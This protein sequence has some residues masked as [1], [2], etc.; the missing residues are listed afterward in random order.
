MILWTH[1]KTPINPVVLVEKDGKLIKIINT[2]IKLP[3]KDVQKKLEKIDPDTYLKRSTLLKCAEAELIE[4]FE[5]NRKKFNIDYALG[6]TDF[7]IKVWNVI[8]SIPYG[9]TFSYGK[10]AKIMDKPKAARAVGSACRSN[11]V[12]VIIPCHRVIAA[13]GNLGDYSGGLVM[14]RALLDLEGVSYKLNK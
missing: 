9:Q 5:D 8:A 12:P 14:K 2:G 13:N 6:G 11:P 3:D 7:Q 1:I 4:Y 10:I